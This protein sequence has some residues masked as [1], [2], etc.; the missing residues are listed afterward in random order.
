MRMTIE[1]VLGLIRHRCR[2]AGNQARFAEQIGV[3]AQYLT[4]VLYG[5]RRP[6]EAMLKAIRVRRIPDVYE[7]ADE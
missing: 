3:S 1:Q 6:S 7:S 4:D 2:E 5:R